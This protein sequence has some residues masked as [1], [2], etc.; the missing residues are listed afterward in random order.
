MLKQFIIFGQYLKQKLKEEDG[1]TWVEYA[2]LVAAV[3]VVVAFVFGPQ[4]K[5]LGN[6]IMNGMSSWYTSMKN[7]IFPTS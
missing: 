2:C 5:T 7:S 3:V 6:T 4:L 1:A